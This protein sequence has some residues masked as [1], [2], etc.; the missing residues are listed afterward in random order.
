[1]HLSYFDMHPKIIF[2]RA[3]TDIS[4][5]YFLPLTYKLDFLDLFREFVARSHLLEPNL[6]HAPSFILLDCSLFH[7]FLSFSYLSLSVYIYMCL[8]I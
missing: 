2:G 3:L 8:Y 6:V 7:A 1:M 5:K 4:A